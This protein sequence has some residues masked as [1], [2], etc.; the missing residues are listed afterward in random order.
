MTNTFN[1]TLSIDAQSFEQK[2]LNCTKPCVVL[3]RA[4][5]SGNAHLQETVLLNFIHN[6]SSLINF[7][8]ADI[9]GASKLARQFN[10]QIVPTLLFFNKENLEAFLPG[11]S[12]QNDVE[13]ALQALLASN[14]QTH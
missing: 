12:S 5:W 14:Y 7:Y 11:L 3:F 8:T 6:Y 10:I 9:D 2:V 1:A 13:K 4:K